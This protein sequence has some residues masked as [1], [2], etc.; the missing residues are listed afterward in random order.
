MY[1]VHG[2]FGS[3]GNGSSLSL[4]QSQSESQS[5][6]QSVNQSQS[7]SQTLFCHK[8]IWASSLFKS[9]SQSISKG[10]GENAFA[11]VKLAKVESAST[12]HFQYKIQ[13]WSIQAQKSQFNWFISL[14][15][16]VFWF[17]GSCVLFDF[18]SCET[19]IHH[20]FVS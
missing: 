19:C 7:I 12:F 8:K 5:L 16:A 11:P 14:I 2:S 1:Q 18:V 13:F 17:T 6:S 20:K 3:I 4:Y 10:F 15:S 9:Q